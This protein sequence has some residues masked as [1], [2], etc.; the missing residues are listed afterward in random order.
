MAAVGEP[1]DFVDPEVVGQATAALGQ[2]HRDRFATGQG[3]AVRAKLLRFPIVLR[4]FVIGQQSN[5]LLSQL[6]E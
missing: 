1:A 2:L 4:K 5:S 3:D 6:A